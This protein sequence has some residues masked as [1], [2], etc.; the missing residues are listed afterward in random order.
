MPKI[1]LNSERF[2]ILAKVSSKGK[3]FIPTTPGGNGTRYP[4]QH[5]KTRKR[6]KRN[7]YWKKIK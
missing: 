2:S 1:N 7:T 6:N 5:N 4:N 3:I